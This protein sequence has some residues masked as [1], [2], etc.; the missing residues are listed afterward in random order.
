[1]ETSVCCKRSGSCCDSSWGDG[2]RRHF[3]APSPVM[4]IRLH[5]MNAQILEVLW[6]TAYRYLIL[7]WCSIQFE[8]DKEHKVINLWELITKIQIPLDFYAVCLSAEKSFSWNHSGSPSIHVL[9][10]PEWEARWRGKSE[11][12]QRG[13]MIRDL[14]SFSRG[15]KR[16]CLTQVQMSQEIETADSV[17]SYKKNSKFLTWT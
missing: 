3:M 7:S 11:T 9:Q 17:P 1:M 12:Y 4:N 13:R 2:H 15:G 16:L 5:M 10:V 14:Q 6:A 8:H